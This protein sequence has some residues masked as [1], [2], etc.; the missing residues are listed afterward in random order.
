MAPFRFRLENILAHRKRME[1]E[2]MQTLAGAVLRRYNLL[3]R[4]E[5]LRKSRAE[6]RERLCR[7]HL[8]TAAERWFLQGCLQILKQDCEAAEKDLLQAGE[9]LDRCRA[10]L[11]RKAQ[12]RSLL[13]RLKEKQTA[14][15]ATLERQKEQ[16]AFDEAATLRYTPASL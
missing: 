10:D 3:A 13:D 15:H 12:E 6:H 2:A 4:R 11:V 5:A 14:A 7:A 1:E 8:L 9:E 16:R